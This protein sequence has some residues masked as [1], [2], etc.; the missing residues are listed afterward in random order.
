LQRTIISLLLV[1]A[2]RT[3]SI[4]FVTNYKINVQIVLNQALLITKSTIKQ[5]T[6]KTTEIGHANV[7]GGPIWL[8]TTCTPTKLIIRDQ[9][10]AAHINISYD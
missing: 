2:H 1:F 9:T 3:Y 10:E 7:V 5:C 8:R 6:G 4:H